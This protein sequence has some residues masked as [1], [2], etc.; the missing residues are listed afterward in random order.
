MFR[1][2]AGQL[3]VDHGGSIATVQI[4]LPVGWRMIRQ[5][6]WVTTHDST[7]LSVLNCEDYRLR[8]S[9]EAQVPWG[10]AITGI[11]S[12][13]TDDPFPVPPYL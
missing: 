7:I 2:V 1:I 8:S 6:L 12:G 13:A 11:G 9:S 10:R 4:A 3:R 5:A